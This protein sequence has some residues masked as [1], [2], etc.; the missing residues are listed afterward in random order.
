MPPKTNHTAV[1]EPEGISGAPL[2]RRLSWSNTKGL[3]LEYVNITHVPR[4]ASGSTR[5]NEITPLDYNEP[6]G[7]EGKNAFTGFATEKG[8]S[9]WQQL[10][11]YEPNLKLSYA[12]V[13]KNN[14]GCTMMG[15]KRRSKTR[16]R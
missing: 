8:P 7:R 11:H 12:K 10:W 15:G 2:K 4:G 5:R 1:R 13:K 6:T 16:R 14:N 9:F 3:P